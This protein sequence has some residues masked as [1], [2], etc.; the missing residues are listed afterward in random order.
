VSNAWLQFGYDSL[1]GNQEPN[2]RVELDTIS[3]GPPEFLAQAW[4]YPLTASVNSSPVVSKDVV[5]FGDDSGTVTAL[6]VQTSQPVWTASVGGQVRT[7]PA[8]GGPDLFVGTD[9]GSRGTIVALSVST[10]KQL[11]ATATSS[12]VDSSPALAGN[13]LYAGSDDGTL[14]DLNQSSGAVNWSAALAGAVEG[15]PAVDPASQIVVVGDDSGAITALS[16]SSGAKL[17]SV[18]SGGPVSASPSLRN[19]VVYVGSGDGYAYALNEHTGALIWKVATPAAIDCTGVLSTSSL[20]GFYVVGS[21]DGT[22]SYLALSNGALNAT[23]NVGG[24]IAGLAGASSWLTA[25]TTNGLLV[26]L[27]RNDGGM[28]W[29]ETSTAGFGVE[30]PTVNGVVYVAGQD[31]TLRAYTPPGIPIP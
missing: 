10:G 6:Q 1:E 28:V 30:A 11:W 19:G 25:T 31:H 29:R 12:A 8:L 23:A 24:P 14:Y 13:S 22:I 3:P 4:A 27:K 26:G 2:D 16:A 21:A 7:S 9:E 15:S 17:W 5:Y 18:T 20:P